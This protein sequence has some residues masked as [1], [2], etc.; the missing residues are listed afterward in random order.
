[1]PYVGVF[2]AEEDGLVELPSDF[3]NIYYVVEP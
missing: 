1:M 3:R 2:S